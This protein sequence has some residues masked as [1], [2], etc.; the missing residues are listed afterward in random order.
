MISVPSTARSACIRARKEVPE[1]GKSSTS[2]NGKHMAPSRTMQAALQAC[3]DNGNW[4]LCVTLRFPGVP[5]HKAPW[6]CQ[7]GTHHLVA[8]MG[9]KELP[10]GLQA[11]IAEEWGKKGE[12]DLGLEGM[13]IPLEK[14][15]VSLDLE[16]HDGA[17]WHG[18]R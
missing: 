7:A 14:P 8:G 18:G 11:G 10:V 9:K 2:K 12:I 5:G 1:S 13:V 3:P 6:N 4:A 15:V 17:M 16:G